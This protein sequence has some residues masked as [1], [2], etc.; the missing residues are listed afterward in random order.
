MAQFNA[1]A[2]TVAILFAIFY[3][4]IK[5]C[6]RILYSPLNSASDAHWSVKLCGLWIWWHRVNERDAPAVQ[7]AH[8]RC[9]PVVRL[10]PNEVSVNDV[11]GGLKPIYD[12]RMPKHDF[13]QVAVSY[14]SDRSLDVS[15]SKQRELMCSRSWRAC[16]GH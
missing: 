16:Y 11:D 15:L 5:L 8:V 4:F 9:G 14:V 6:Y 13:Y 12:G 3:F 1:L 10:G 2:A 7:D